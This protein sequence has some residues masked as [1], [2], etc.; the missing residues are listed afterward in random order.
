MVNFT[1]PFYDALQ[2]DTPQHGCFLGTDTNTLFRLIAWQAPLLQLLNGA[3]VKS[4]AT[5]KLFSS[6]CILYIRG[7]C[8]GKMYCTHLLRHFSS[9]K[10]ALI[11]SL[12]SAC[13]SHSDQPKLSVSFE[14]HIGEMCITVMPRRTSQHGDRLCVQ[15]NAATPKAGAV[16]F[17]WCWKYCA[18]IKRLHR[19]ADCKQGPQGQK[20][21]EWNPAL[22][23]PCE[24][25][26]S[27]RKNQHCSLDSNL[28]QWK[29]LNWEI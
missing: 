9:Q 18:E 28:A 13:S 1:S 8:I 20:L 2:R 24:C 5:N 6:A 12:E 26:T 23:G 22:L 29:L 25:H 16:R 21:P 17:P 10:R 15:E 14:P 7:L 3:S 19:G 11:R 27:P 4:M